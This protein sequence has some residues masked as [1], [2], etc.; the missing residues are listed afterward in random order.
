MRGLS[1]RRRHEGPTVRIP[2]WADPRELDDAFSSVLSPDVPVL[3]LRQTTDFV[4]FFSP[5]LPSLASLTCL[6]CDVKFGFPPDWFSGNDATADGPR[7]PKYD[8]FRA[9]ALAWRGEHSEYAL[10]P[11]GFLEEYGAYI[12]DD[13]CRIVGFRQIPEN[14]EAALDAYWHSCFG[15]AAAQLAGFTPPPEVAFFCLDG[16]RW[17]LFARDDALLAVVLTHLGPR[18]DLL[19]QEMTLEESYG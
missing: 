15:N 1:V 16:C 6:L 18:D 3:R 14:P 7:G 2:P 17:E 4:E 19:L 10:V 11:A 9:K 5:L 8:A 12:F 13:W